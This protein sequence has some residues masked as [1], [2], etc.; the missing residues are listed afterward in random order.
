MN[1]SLSFPDIK[2][3][4]ENVKP[5]FSGAFTNFESFIPNSY[6][7]ILVFTLLHRASKLC[8]NCEL[9]QQEIKHLKNIF[10]KNGYPV[11]L[12]DFYIKKYL[13]NLHV[14]KEVFLSTPKN[15]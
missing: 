7:C 9:F 2:I 15:S 6:K 1:S 10:R 12:I 8:S 3:I 4:R 11:N 13:D 14:K 5:I